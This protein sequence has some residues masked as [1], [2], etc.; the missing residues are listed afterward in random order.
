MISANVYGPWILATEERRCEKVGWRDD[1][2]DEINEE[3][4]AGGSGKIEG[5]EDRSVS[6][7]RK[8]VV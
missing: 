1:S 4:V 3:R 2:V 6:R 5:I 8:S 7:D